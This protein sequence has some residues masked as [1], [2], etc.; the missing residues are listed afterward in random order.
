ML[1][2]RTVQ[3]LLRNR[4]SRDGFGNCVEDYQG[5]ADVPGVLIAPGR[6]EDLD[7]SRPEGV[8]VALTLHFPKGY[9]ADLRGAKV[10]L[11]GEFAGTYRII[12]DPKPYQTELCP[13]RWNRPAEVEAV[14]G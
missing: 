7:A 12:G 6:C 8:K 10:V 9:D 2:G 14:D 5:A 3:V 13:L 1:R 4:D 11:D